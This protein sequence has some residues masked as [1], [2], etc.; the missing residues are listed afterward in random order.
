MPQVRVL[1]PERRVLVDTYEGEPLQRL[2][3]IVGGPE[4][5]R[6]HHGGS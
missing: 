6:V 5:G 1:V 2:S 3:D 4:G